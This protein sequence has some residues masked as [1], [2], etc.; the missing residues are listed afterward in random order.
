LE[1]SRQFL[2]ALSRSCLGAWVG[3]LIYNSKDH[4]RAFKA[5]TGSSRF[6]AS[7]FMKFVVCVAFWDCFYWWFISI[8]WVCFNAPPHRQRFQDWLRN[9]SKKNYFSQIPNPHKAKKPSTKVESFSLV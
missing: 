5:A 6:L 8:G 7:S 1:F 2:W 3:E 9:A 4:N